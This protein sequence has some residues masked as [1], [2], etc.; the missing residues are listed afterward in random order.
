[1]WK[2]V[3]SECVVDAV[4]TRDAAL[5]ATVVLFGR[6]NLPAVDAMWCHVGSLVW[7]DVDGYSSAWRSWG[8]FV[9]IKV[10]KETGVGRELGLA[11]RQAKEIECDIGL[12]HQ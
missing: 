8:P 2:P 12:G 11:P 1:M 4:G 3:D 6:A 9:V 10:A 7:R 5:V